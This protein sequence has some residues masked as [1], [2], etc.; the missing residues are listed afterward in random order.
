MTRSIWKLP[1]NNS[2][3]LKQAKQKNIKKR[4]YS[5][6]CTILPSHYG[7]KWSIYNG[8]NWLDLKIVE[9][10]VGHKFGEFSST[11]K[12]ANHKLKKQKQSSRSTKSIKKAK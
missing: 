12:K 11:R 8:K 3:A 4:V 9:E 10:M 2:S 6:A 7:E 5:R 1:F